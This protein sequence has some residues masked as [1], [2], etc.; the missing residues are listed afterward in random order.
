MLWYAVVWSSWE[1]VERTGGTGPGRQLRMQAALPPPGHLVDVPVCGSLGWSVPSW[2][3]TALEATS[4]LRCPNE[5]SGVRMCSLNAP[6]HP[7]RSP[8]DWRSVRLPHE[9]TPPDLL[10]W[11]RPGSRGPYGPR[12]SGEVGNFIYIAL[13]RLI[14]SFSLKSYIRL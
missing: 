3:R 10:H 9:E 7:R 5:R 4:T 8:L 11:P 1:G 13:G 12:A 2:R 6:L 14:M